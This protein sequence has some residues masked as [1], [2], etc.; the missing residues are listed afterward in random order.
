M[1]RTVNYL[2]CTFP[3]VRKE[4]KIVPPRKALNINNVTRL[5]AFR[6]V[7]VR[8]YEL[9]TDRCGVKTMRR[10]AIGFKEEKR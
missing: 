8:S 1:L 9:T 10:L 2:S 4:K 3:K 7:P 6:A 5:T